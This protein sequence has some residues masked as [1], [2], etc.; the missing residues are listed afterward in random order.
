[1]GRFSQGKGKGFP[2]LV[3]RIDRGRGGYI[4]DRVVHRQADKV[5]EWVDSHLRR[6]RI[7][8]AETDVSLGGYWDRG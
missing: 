6:I 5:R 8:K 4:Q 1:M 7:F 2:L 3:G